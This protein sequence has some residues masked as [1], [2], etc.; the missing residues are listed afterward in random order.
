MYAKTQILDILDKE[1]TRATDAYNA[2]ERELTARKPRHEAAR[3]KWVAETSQLIGTA[4]SLTDEAVDN[5]EAYE[6][7]TDTLSKLRD[8][9]WHP[10]PFFA[11]SREVH[12]ER[13]RLERLEFVRSVVDSHDK[14]KVSHEML[15]DLGLIRLVKLA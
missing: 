15:K 5:P 11:P 10:L 9:S 12:Q 6:K 2:A 13:S 14:E 4:L 3:E 1:I 7:Y 8:R